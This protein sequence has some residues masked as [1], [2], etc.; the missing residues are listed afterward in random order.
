MPGR[1]SACLAAMFLASFGTTLL[2]RWPGSA[3]TGAT[4]ESFHASPGIASA[5]RTVAQAT[6]SSD[7]PAADSQ[8]FVPDPVPESL[9]SLS[10][11]QTADD[12]AEEAALASLAGQEELDVGELYLADP[13]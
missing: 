3:G 7:R 1:A 11:E 4:P 13:G 10:N 8:P 2:L 12:L 9:R 5:T 6:E